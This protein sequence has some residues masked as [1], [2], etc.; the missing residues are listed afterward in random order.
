M[1]KIISSKSFDFAIFPVVP[2]DY[3]LW[4]RTAAFV[5]HLR[6]RGFFVNFFDIPPASPFLY[7]KDPVTYNRGII[8]FLFP[9][10]RFFDNLRIF[11]QPPIFPAS[12]FEYKLLKRYN[13]EKQYFRILKHYL[14]MIKMKKLIA[15][16]ETPWWYDIIKKLKFSLLCYDCSDDLKVFC[17]KKQFEYFSVLQKN[18]VEKADLV[19]ITAQRLKTD[20]T[21]IRPDAPIEYLP[22]GVDADFFIKKGSNASAPLK[23]RNLSR[24]II[25]FVG[26]LYSW[27]NIRLIEKL[28]KNYPNFSIVLVGP[29]KNIKLPHLLNIHHIAREPYS[30]IPEYINAFDVCII[31]F[32]D[33]PLSDK[34]DPVK[35]YEYL[36]LGKPVVAINLPELERIKHLIYL[37]KDEN[38]FIFFIQQALQENNLKLKL[39]RIQYARENSWSV[40][41]DRLLEIV[42]SRLALKLNNSIV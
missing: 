27:I 33:D 34:V 13:R 4:G 8:D 23:L 2:Y 3:L 17:N 21:N 6:K 35:V 38:E 26:A 37:A 25:G 18:L 16:V 42:T 30:L 1:N 19:S 7:F 41:I 24:P 12:R 29:T 39:E 15:I 11:P 20:I 36:S 10:P 40:R 28:A 5:Y 32:I 22:N 14:P 9:K 31:P